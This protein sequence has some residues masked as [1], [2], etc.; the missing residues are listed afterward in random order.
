MEAGDNCFMKD[1]L[2]YFRC[3]KEIQV[4]NTKRY[5]A[6]QFFYGELKEKQKAPKK[7]E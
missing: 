6:C 4:E 1:S 5:T 3:N 2:I 7:N